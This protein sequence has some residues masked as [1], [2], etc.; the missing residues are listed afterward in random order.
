MIKI[1][2]A[3][4]E[5]IP[6][7]LV[8]LKKF[9]EIH[10][11]RASVIDEETAPDLI[12]ALVEQQVVF[13]AEKSGEQLGFIGGVL[14]PHYFNPKIKVL[15]ETFWWVAEEHRGSRAALLL[16]KEFVE[17]G[18]VHADWITMALEA[19]SPV[20]EKCLTKRGFKLQERA[21]LMEVS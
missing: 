3:Q 5:D 6:W 4:A 20:N 7:L 12:K 8:E 2:R 21:F 19:L 15:A 9:A 16:M 13:I 18:K 1:R 10:D 17:Y 11:S 14:M